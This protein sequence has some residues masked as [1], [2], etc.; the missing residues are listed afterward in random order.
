MH[1]MTKLQFRDT[2]TRVFGVIDVNRA[3]QLTNKVFISTATKK[4]P[5]RT[6]LADAQY[7]DE[8]PSH[9]IEV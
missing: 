9:M 5:A 2:G 7:L 3:D 6:L 8:S 4:Q 1:K